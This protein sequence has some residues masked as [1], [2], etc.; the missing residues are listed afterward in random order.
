MPWQPVRICMQKHTHVAK[1]HQKCIFPCTSR[2]HIIETTSFKYAQLK[3]H[4]TF[5]LPCQLNNWLNYI[6]I[7]S[8][9]VFHLRGRMIHNFDHLLQGRQFLRLPVCF[10]VLQ[11]PSEKGSTS[12]TNAAPAFSNSISKWQHFYVLYNPWQFG[13]LFDDVGVGSRSCTLWNPLSLEQTVPWGMGG[14]A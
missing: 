13:H 6:K 14:D 2:S 4:W 7:N 8:L 12:K 10:P 5:L 9:V 1:N 3:D 11:V